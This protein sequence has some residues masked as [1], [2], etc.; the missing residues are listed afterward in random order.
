MILTSYGK[1]Q[2]NRRVSHIQ[3]RGQ[4][5]M[6]SPCSKR[7]ALCALRVALCAMLFLLSA[8]GYHLRPSGEPV[9]GS[10]DS[11]AIPMMT[12]TSS[13]VG[14]ESDFT[15]IVRDEFISHAKVPLTAQ[16]E[17]RYLLVGRIHDIRTDPQSYSYLQQTVQGHE[18]TFAETNRRRLTLTLSISM[19]EKATGKVVWSDQTMMTRASYDVGADPLVNQYNQ[20]LALERIARRLAQQIYM[21]TMERF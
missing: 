18:T 15:R 10:V 9:G 7:S 21:R 14:F 6:I 16:E 17:A 20:R 3:H 1:D 4:R 12:S 2:G 11:L 19:V 5:T 8:C 13:V